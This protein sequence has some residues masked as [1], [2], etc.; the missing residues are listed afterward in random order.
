LGFKDKIFNVLIANSS[1]SVVVV[2][3]VLSTKV[4][5]HRAREEKTAK[6]KLLKPRRRDS[7]TV[8]VITPSSSSSSTSASERSGAR[9]VGETV[10][11][12]AGWR[13]LVSRW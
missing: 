8:A 4:I 13:K 6:R 3:R 12:Q 5:Q 9:Y 11:E 1:F 10:P 7:H 2:E